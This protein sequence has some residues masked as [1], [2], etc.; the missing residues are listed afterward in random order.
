VTSETFLNCA[1]LM[2]PLPLV[3]LTPA[4]TACDIDTFWLP[5]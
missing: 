5:K 4:A 3:A 1:L 2:L